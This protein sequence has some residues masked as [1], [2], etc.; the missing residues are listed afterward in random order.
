MTT[1]PR[2]LPEALKLLPHGPEFR[3]LDRLLNFRMATHE[4]RIGRRIQE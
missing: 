3:F 1:M 4:S 2:P